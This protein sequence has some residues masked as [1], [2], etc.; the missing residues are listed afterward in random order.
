MRNHTEIIRDGGGPLA[1]AEQLG[2]AQFYTVRSWHAR[3]SIPRWAWKRLADAGLASL[4]ELA[5]E[6]ARGRWQRPQTQAG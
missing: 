3:N 5:D 4:E 6:A 1:V 2:L